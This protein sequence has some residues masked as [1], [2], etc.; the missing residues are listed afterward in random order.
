VPV[1]RFP[2]RFVRVLALLA[3]SGAS[4][5][6]ACK[7]ASPPARSALTDDFGDTIALAVR[8]TRIASL[9]PA[10]TELWFAIGAGAR[11]VGR[12]SYDH[13]PAEA[14]A[15][16]DLG[17]GIRPNVETVLAARPDLVVLYA[18]NDNRDVARRLRAAGIPTVAY[19]VDRIA[20]FVRVTRAL[21]AL[22]GD[23]AA[24]RVTIDSVSATLDRVRR[25]TTGLPRPTVFWPLWDNPLLAVGGGSFLNELIAIA[26]GRNVYESL[27]QP[28]PSITFED[29]VQR[30]P[31]F[32]LAGAVKSAKIRDDARWRTLR[33]VRDGKV[34]VIDTAVTMRPAV[35][36]GEGAVSLARMLHPGVLP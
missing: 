3:L 8:P 34:I 19:R 21:G 14:S 9:N 10:T 13:W 27:P 36:L 31:D 7:A 17:P 2:P 18:S 20:D 30:D 15:V 23:T 22:T 11:L 35:R 12:T 26:G 32:V 29:L 25:A 16:P 28:S 6:A 4:L 5:F 24:A 1:V 33:A